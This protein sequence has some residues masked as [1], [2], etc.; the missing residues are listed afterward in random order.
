MSEFNAGDTVEVLPSNGLRFREGP[1][2]R[3][4]ILRV[5]GKY[6]QL[7]VLELPY[8]PPDTN[9]DWLYLEHS[10]GQRGW[11]A[12][13]SNQSGVEYL[14]KAVPQ[15]E[16]KIEAWPTEYIERPSSYKNPI[17]QHQGARIPVYAKFGL[18]KGHNG[19]DLFAPLNSEIYAAHPGEVTR[20]SFSPTGYG[21]NV[22]VTNGSYTT[23]YAHLK[24]NTQVSVGDVVAAGDLLGYSGD[25]GW[26]SGPHLHF[27][28]RDV[29]AI[30][31]GS[32]QYEGEVWGV[33]DIEGYVNDYIEQ[34]R[35]ID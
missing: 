25:T 7:E 9:Y 33:V 29:R 26:S 6:E 24:G 31:P 10:S 5:L 15:K 13:K 34:A 19:I 12:S 35:G 23:I 1:D 17:T 30:I 21:W 27:E 3:M 4:P 28:L 2:L 20:I 8:E 18:R 32:P 11:S 16:F 22:R 14:D